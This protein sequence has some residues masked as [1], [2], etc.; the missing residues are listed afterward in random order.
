VAKRLNKGT[1]SASSILSGLLDGIY[2]TN[3]TFDHH[4]SHLVQKNFL[5]KVQEKINN[6]QTESIIEDLYQMVHILGNS[7]NKFLHVAGNA[8]KMIEK[9][10]QNVLVFNKIFNATESPTEAELKER[11][12][13]TKES[14]YRSEDKSREQHVALGVDS[15]SSCFMTQTVLYNN[16]DWSL[17]E[18]GQAR[19]MLKYLSDR[20]YH[21][22]GGQGLTYSI[23]M[24]LSVSTGR[25]HLSLSKSSQLTGAYKVVREIF[26]NYTQ[27]L[28]D[29]DETLAESAKGALIYSWAEKEETVSGLVTQSNKAYMRGTDT[30]YNRQFT[31]SIADVDVDQ[32]KEIGRRILPLFL[33]ENATQTVVVCNNGR[34]AKIVDDMKKMFEIDF[35]LF[36][37]YEETYLNFE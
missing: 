28:T 14:S 35:K 10:G 27:G 25:V 7:N 24:A 15:T 2:Y 31:K 32:V 33:D 18:V 12:E 21:Q 13:L 8:E 6:N 26:K 29:W 4:T 23:S 1:P 36:D 30:Q 34:I 17:P 19:V 3:Q 20:L 16:T 11:F 9:Y 5:N 22:V 37:K